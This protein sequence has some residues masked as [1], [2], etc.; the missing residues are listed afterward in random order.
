[1]SKS[2]KIRTLLA[3]AQKFVGRG[4][5]DRA[6][7]SIT[8]AIE[9]LLEIVEGNVATSPTPLADTNDVPTA[10]VAEGLKEFNDGDIE[11]F[12]IFTPSTLLED[13]ATVASDTEEVVHP[14][15]DVEETLIAPFVNGIADLPETT[16]EEVVPVETSVE[17]VVVEPVVQDEIDVIEPEAPEEEVVDVQPEDDT[18]GKKRKKK[19]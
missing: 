12:A 19:V 8:A 17:D 10:Y 1:M 18:T 7:N 13:E 15:L 14:D 6:T 3:D 2:V 16:P 9:L 5:M 11:K 4:S